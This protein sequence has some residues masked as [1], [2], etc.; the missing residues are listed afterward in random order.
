MIRHSSRTGTSF[1]ATLALV[2]VAADAGAAATIPPPGA[3]ITL[4]PKFGPVTFPHQRHSELD[5]VTCS[6]CHHTLD[7]PDGE[8]RSCYLCHE[9]KLFRIAAIRRADPE[10][11]Q[12]RGP[13]VPDAQEA[14]HSLC[15]GCHHRRRQQSLEAGPDD[16]CRDCHR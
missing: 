10:Q 7:S 12:E 11:A 1:P 6:T 9:A 4:T 8:V 5:G 14:F 16:S 15:T 13:Q 2:L 3:V